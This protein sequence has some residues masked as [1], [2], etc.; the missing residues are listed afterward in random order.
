M[1]ANQVTSMV[2]AHIDKSTALKL[3]NKGTYGVSYIFTLGYRPFDIAPLIG[4][5]T[6]KALSKKIKTYVENESYIQVVKSVPYDLQAIMNNPEDVLAAIVKKTIVSITYEA[7]NE[8]LTLKFLNET[9]YAS[10]YL[11]TCGQ[12]PINIADITGDYA[13]QI[14]R[15]NIEEIKKEIQT[16]VEFYKDQFWNF[17]L[18]LA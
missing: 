4:K 3:I 8:S 1:T 9:L 6:V 10:S 14:L 2:Q 16:N 11:L 5:A 12:R 17:K 13:D 15:E 18:P 7:I